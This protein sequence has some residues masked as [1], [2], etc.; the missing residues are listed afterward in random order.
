VLLVSNKTRRE[1][2]NTTE[3][4][5]EQRRLNTQKEFGGKTMTNRHSNKEISDPNSILWYNQLVYVQ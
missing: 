1:G 3:K 2:E 5:T 4:N